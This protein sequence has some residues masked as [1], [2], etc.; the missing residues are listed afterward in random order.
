VIPAQDISKRAKQ[1]HMSHFLGSSGNLNTSEEGKQLISNCPIC[2]STYKKV[3]INTL[4]QNDEA[5]LFHAKCNNCKD[6]LMAMITL[7]SLGMS[8]IGI[9][10]DL[11][12][13]DT[14]RLIGSDP[15]S[16][17]HLLNFHSFLK[18]EQKNFF[19]YL[20]IK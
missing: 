16:E 15:V 1:R 5:E 2:K 3:D 14:K 13:E 8:V 10:T 19:N 12:L 18:N 20:K 6:K 4:D 9:M 17:D 11:T 7:T